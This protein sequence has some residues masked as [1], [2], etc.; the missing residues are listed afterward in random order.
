MAKKKSRKII[1]SQKTTIKKR[2]GKQKLKAALG[3]TILDLNNELLEYKDKKYY[4]DKNLLNETKKQIQSEEG[5]K[6]A[7]KRHIT[8]LKKEQIK[9]GTTKTKIK[10][11]DKEIHGRKD[12][13]VEYKGTKRKINLGANYDYI[14][15]LNNKIKRLKD[16][17]NMYA[18]KDFDFT[19]NTGF[20][21]TKIK[22][23]KLISELKRGVDVRSQLINKTVSDINK[24]EKYDKEQLKKARKRG[25]KA[26][27]SHY[28]KRMN[29]YKKLRNSLNFNKSL[30]ETG[31]DYTETIKLDNKGKVIKETEKYPLYIAFE[32][33]EIRINF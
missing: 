5:F 6:N 18:G 4:Q 26:K 23:S 20:S 1:V 12:T 25:D 21:K 14:D 11:I 16:E 31:R 28:A 19:V 33:S 9:R 27:Q 10:E 13:M 2:T 24:F 3:L 8:K 32:G 7:I 17:N 15:K 22:K 30:V 29:V